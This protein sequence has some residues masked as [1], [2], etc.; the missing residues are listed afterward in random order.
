MAARRKQK[1]FQNPIELTVINCTVL[2]FLF[3]HRL[4]HLL[5][6]YTYIYR[7]ERH[8]VARTPNIKMYFGF[9]RFYSVAFY[10]HIL[11]V[12]LYIGPCKLFL[13]PATKQ[14]KKYFRMQ[15]KTANKGVC[16]IRIVYIILAIVACA[17]SLVQIYI[18]ICI[19][20]KYAMHTHEPK[21]IWDHRGIIA[22]TI[23]RCYSSTVADCLSA[24]A[25]CAML[26]PSHA[27]HLSIE[28]ES[29][30]YF[31]IQIKRGH[32]VAVHRS[33]TLLLLWTD[34]SVYLFIESCD[35]YWLRMRC[36]AVFGFDTY[37]KVYIHGNI[38]NAAPYVVI[39]ARCK[40]WAIVR[41]FCSLCNV[42]A[43][44]AFQERES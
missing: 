21:S 44:S 12:P 6:E 9:I 43:Q 33:Q 31:H 4:A 36:D 5:A 22:H 40:P 23:F 39:V 3:P 10:I 19:C 8:S 25:P 28:G 15:P 27:D 24:C 26:H 17:R 32:V 42:H 35:D 14:T 41:C 2:F 29:Y 7:I 30:R 37:A 16:I 1:W 18:S 13:L 11:S 34:H 38:P 20:G